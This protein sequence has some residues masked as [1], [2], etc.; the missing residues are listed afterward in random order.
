MAPIGTSAARWSTLTQT[1]GARR[2]KSSKRCFA[3]G[4]TRQGLRHRDSVRTP[5]ARPA[6]LLHVDLRM[7]VCVPS[8][9]PVPRI[10]SRGLRA[11]ESGLDSLLVHP[12]VSRSAD[13]RRHQ[14]A[15][16]IQRTGNG[17]DLRTR[18]HAP[19]AS[20][21]SHRHTQSQTVRVSPV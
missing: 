19:Q 3:R 20:S 16:G 21:Q 10:R 6:P 11:P 7:P 18:S 12:S 1:R 14:G 4:T 8:A 17:R 2:R 5:G 15:E 9:P 13:N